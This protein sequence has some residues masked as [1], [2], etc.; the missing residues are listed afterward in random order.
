MLETIFRPHIQPI[1]NALSSRIPPTIT[2]NSITACGLVSGL[3]AG[4]AISQHFLLIGLVLLLVCGLFDILDGSVARKQILNNP[5]GA[6]IDLIADRLAESAIII[7]FA[8]GY[9][10]YSIAYVIFLAGVLFHFSTFLAAAAL[11]KNNGIKSIYYDESLI[12]RAEA[13]AV[14]AFMCVFPGLIFESLM[15]FNCLVYLTASA[16]CYRI[17]TPLI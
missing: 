9:P 14:F 1:F 10:E 11:F 2:P 12:E 3:F 7:G 5:M 17:L 13:F 6:Y 8:V 4:I 16:R 15:I